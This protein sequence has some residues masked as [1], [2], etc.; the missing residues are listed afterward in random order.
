MKGCKPAAYHLR[1]VDRR[2]L[3]GIVRDGRQL[4]RVARRAHILLALDRG[5]RII[6]IMRWFNVS[7]MG[8]WHVWQRYQQRGVG[9]IVDEERRGRPS[10][11]SPAGAR[12]N[13]TDGMYR[14]CCVR[15]A[16]HALGLSELAAV[17]DRA[18]RG[19]EHP[20]YHGGADFG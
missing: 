8:I 9:A 7:R 17:R 16:P 10:V 1:G 5:E 20:L 18:G 11:F 4:Q 2:Y 19:G 3:Q 13:R 15:V 12:A 14:S 6:E